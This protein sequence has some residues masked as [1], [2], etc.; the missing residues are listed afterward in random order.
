MKFKIF[1]ISAIYLLKKSLASQG[2]LIRV[3]DGRKEIVKLSIV[4]P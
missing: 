3:N 1:E 4:L 2:I